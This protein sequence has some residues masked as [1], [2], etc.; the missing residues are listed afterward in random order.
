[1]NLEAFVD[2]A[3]TGATWILYLLIGLS[4]LQVAVMIERAWVFFRARASKKELTAIVRDGIARDDLDSVAVALASARSLEARV[5]AAGARSAHM[6]AEAS[7]E[8]MHGTLVEERTRLESRLSFLGTLG[9]NAPFIGLFG[10]VLGIIHAFADLAQQGAGQAS[11]TVMSGISEALVA[12][13]IGLIVALPA[14]VAF[15]YFQRKIKVR[16]AAAETLS[17]LILAHLKRH[18]RSASAS[19]SMRKAA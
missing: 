9:N 18:H 6:G 1:M 10:T 7:D 11:R 16:A 2:L 12:T 3:G 4:T 8:I 15:N 14:V 17:G 5:V 19:G 13:A